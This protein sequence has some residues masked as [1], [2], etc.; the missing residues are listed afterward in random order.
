VR[1]TQLDSYFHLRRGLDFRLLITPPGSS[2]KRVPARGD[3]TCW[4]L[5]DLVGF[6]FVDRL[7]TQNEVV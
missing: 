4:A 1:T 7:T 3:E 2:D 6:L 5:F